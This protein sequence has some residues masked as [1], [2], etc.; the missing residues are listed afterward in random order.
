MTIRTNVSDASRR[1]QT[2][3]SRCTIREFDDDH[4]MMQIKQADVYHSETPTNFERWQQCGFTAH[5][6]KQDQDQSQQ[7][8]Q[9]QNG[10]G[11]NGPGQGAGD[12]S[13]NQPKGESSEG[14]MLY[15]NGSRA[16]PVCVSV[17]DRRV[18][19]YGM[20]EGES[21]LYACDGSGQMVY[22]RVR[23]DANDGL[24]LV[25]L[26][27]QEQSKDGQQ[28]ERF[29]S[30][31][32]VEKKK[33]PR[34]K[35]KAGGGAGQQADGGNGGSSS[36][37]KHE[38]DTVNTEVRI[39][40]QMIEFRDGDQSV[41]HYDKGKQRWTHFVNGDATKGSV[42]VDKDHVHIRFGDHRIWVDKDGCWSSEAIQ[43]KA[44]PYDS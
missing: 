42:V 28:Q 6:K 18:R 16:H 19:P 31:R 3:I 4:D 35:K 27:D 10:N 5:P 26:N 33:Q 7:G 30:L 14:I 22:H 2:S 8:Q 39:S 23:G 34:K 29:L 1:A 37:F 36:D 21:A 11:G 13:N 12:I 25:T 41:G 24:Y 44:D 40:K 43:V 20:K 9:Q 17:D 38:G 15:V 32:H